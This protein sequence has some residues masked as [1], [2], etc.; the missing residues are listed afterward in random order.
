MQGDEKKLEE[1]HMAGDENESHD[2]SGAEEAHDGHDDLDKPEDKDHE[3]EAN[4]DKASDYTVGYQKVD[5]SQPQQNKASE[6]EQALK[7]TFHNIK[8]RV[9]KEVFSQVATSAA[10]RKITL[11]G[12][13]IAVFL[14]AYYAFSSA[15]K[16][17][18][19]D[20]EKKAQA[21]LE[22]RKDDLIKTAKPITPLPSPSETEIKVEVPKLPSPPP[23]V[24]PQPPEPPPLPVPVAPQPPVFPS[25]P[26][27]PAVPQ[28]PSVSANVNVGASPSS[29]V[30]SPLGIE[31]PES[32]TTVASLLTGKD[33]EEEKKKKFEERRKANSLI[34]GGGG[35]VGSDAASKASGK[36]DDKED[37]AAGGQKASTDKSEFLGFGE[38]SFGEV[39]L[40]KTAATQVK[41]TYVG[42][43]DSMIAQGKI[44]YAILETAISTDLPG[45]LRAVITRDVYAESGKAVL[46]PKGS[47]VVGDYQTQ[48]KNG[49][50]RVGVKWSR[51]IRP[52]GIDLQLDSS[53]VDQLGRSGVEGFTDN[54]FWLQIGAAVLT[55]YIIPSL[56]NRIANVKDQAITSTTTTGP[57][58]TTTTTQG[59]TT[60]SSQL[61]QSSQQFQQIAQDVISKSLNTEPV[62]SVDQGTR[63][64]IYV[65]KDVVFPSDI[66]IKSMKVVKN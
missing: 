36:Q 11:I 22:E 43:L 15:N 30:T 6:E 46:I 51:L 10:N 14:V 44:I 18:K 26:Q 58:G 5:L 40:A 53:G 12:L 47:R 65:N 64:N 37:K 20:V 52:D 39:T 29:S 31:S 62:I 50:S 16:E 35:G 27:A 3:V 41:A 19:Q 32:N 24:T 34:L 54:K 61:Q 13:A 55:S 56:A 60:G 21:Q 59:G 42:K 63:I 1:Q 38:G 17:S 7:S 9:G 2:S 8:D 49:Q 33:A 25:A 57:S 66:A 28:V 45:T 4:E 23:L 48:I